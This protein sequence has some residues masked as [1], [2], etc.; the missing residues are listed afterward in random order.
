[1]TIVYLAILIINICNLVVIIR[2]NKTL[3][4]T[5]KTQIDKKS[6]ESGVKNAI[7]SAAKKQKGEV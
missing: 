6:I 2:L 1:M 7:Y 3:E 5:Y 4:Q